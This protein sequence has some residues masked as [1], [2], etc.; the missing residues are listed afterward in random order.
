MINDDHESLQKSRKNLL[1][2]WTHPQEFQLI[3]SLAISPVATECLGIVK[4]A[5]QIA[6]KLRMSRIGDIGS[7]NP[8]SDMR[9]GDIVNEMTKVKR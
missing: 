4:N 1:E 3:P 7:L 2:S 6:W 9:I 8:K 5:E